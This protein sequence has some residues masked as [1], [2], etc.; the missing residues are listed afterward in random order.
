MQ[1]FK[2]RLIDADF[3]AGGKAK[4]RKGEI[5]G[6]YVV[7]VNTRM[8]QNWLDNAMY[9]RKVGVEPKS[10]VLPEQVSD[11]QDLFEQLLNERFDVL[12]G[13]HIR[14]DQTT[15]AVDLR[16]TFR[17]VRTAAE[18]YTNGNWARL[19]ESRPQDVQTKPQRLAE[20]TARRKQEQKAESKGK[21]FIRKPT[22]PLLKGR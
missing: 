10:I 2:R 8:T 19:P 7:S 6:I 17:Y 5:D 18:V 20:R 4:R 15:V 14:I 16:D 3:S 1:W 9:R 11:D 12:E 22:N 21:R 13:K